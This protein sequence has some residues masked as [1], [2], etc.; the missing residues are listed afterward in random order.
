VFQPGYLTFEALEK[1]LL[2]CGAAVFLATRT[3][4]RRFA[5]ERSPPA[6]A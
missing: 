1:M 3:T 6:P 2:D 4:K 5:R